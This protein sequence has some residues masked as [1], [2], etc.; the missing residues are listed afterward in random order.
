MKKTHVVIDFTFDTM[1]GLTDNDTI[2]KISYNH[3]HQ[4]QPTTLQPLLQEQ[5]PSE[6]ENINCKPSLVLLKFYSPLYHTISVF[7]H[8][9]QQ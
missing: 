5:E 9:L 1:K 8:P 4:D 7:G 2:D 6:Q 3:T